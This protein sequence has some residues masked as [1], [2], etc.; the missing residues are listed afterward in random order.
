MLNTSKLTHRMVCSGMVLAAQL[1]FAV[2]ANAEEGAE[3]FMPNDAEGHVYLTLEACTLPTNAPEG[4]ELH[5]AYSVALEGTEKE[6][7]FEGC[8]TSPKLDLSTIPQEY[9]SKA[10]RA[11]V[12]FAENGMMVNQLLS[13]FKPKTPEAAVAGLF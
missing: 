6:Q 12:I 13:D 4:T 10:E 5:R 11:V 3:L 8:W 7:K 1:A 9:V 2:P